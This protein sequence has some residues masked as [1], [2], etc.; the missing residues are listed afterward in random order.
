MD[1]TNIEYI[2]LDHTLKDADFV[3]ARK[4]ML[5]GMRLMS[6]SQQALSPNWLGTNASEEMPKFHVLGGGA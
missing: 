1:N 4:N 6:N 2:E 3:L 5:A